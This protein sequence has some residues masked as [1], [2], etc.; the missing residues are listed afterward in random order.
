MFQCNVSLYCSSLHFSFHIFHSVR[1]MYIHFYRPISLL[2]KQKVIVTGILDF[3]EHRTVDMTLLSRD[4]ISLLSVVE[5]RSIIRNRLKLTSLCRTKDAIISHVLK[6]ASDDLLL[7]L[8]SSIRNKY[9]FALRE[10]PVALSQAIRDTS[11]YL[12][13]PDQDRLD[14][15]YGEFLNATG[16]DAL[17]LVTCAV[18]AREVS[19]V[20]DKV[21]VIRVVDIP[22]IH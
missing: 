10:R 4:D 3:G 11:R 5:I 19:V 18:C 6:Y 7:D 8:K 13:I 2:E 16:N 22:N 1:Q 12:D 17:R 21:E 20:K 15:C 9:E 14:H